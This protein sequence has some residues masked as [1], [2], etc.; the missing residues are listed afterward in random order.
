[1]FRRSPLRSTG[2]NAFAFAAALFL[3][4]VLAPAYSQ[5]MDFERQ[6][7]RAM[8]SAIKED[9]K[10]NYFDPNFRGIDLEARFKK[11]DEDI[12]AAAALGQITTI[13]AQTLLDLHDSHTYFVPPSRYYQTEYGWRMQMIG[14]KCYVV[15]VKP[16]TDAASKGLKEG[17][18]LVSV[19]GYNPTRDSLWIL[20]YFYNTLAP[21]RQMKLVVQG[22]DGA[23][24]PLEVAAK[25]EQ[26]KK[27]LRD[28]DYYS[29]IRA[30]ENEAHM[31]RHIYYEGLDGDV[32]LW[33]MPQFD[34]D[35]EDV[36][37]MMSK[38]K[39]HKA[40]ILDLRG[41]GGG[42]EITMQR[43]LGHLFDRDINIG[44]LKGRKESKPVLAKTRGADNFKGKLVVLIDS[45]S[46]SAAEVVAR[47]VQL[48]KRGTV[49]GDRSAGAVMRAKFYEHAH[50]QDIVLYYGVSVTDSDLVMTD[51]KS[52]EGA[53]VVPDSVM[54]PTAA[55]LAARRDPVLAHAA[56]LVG[57]EINAEKAGTLFPFEW[58]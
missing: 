6:R 52:L 55:D 2:A 41:N 3:L 24:R 39:K 53:G 36:D 4:S 42:Y 49:I 57:L 9:I 28:T 19:N 45:R 32:F 21:Q 47:V 20:N 17:D 25:V 5:T 37:K 44:D 27:L 38:V 35:N 54:L 11:A 22:P 46:G 40:L 58:K 31:N 1:M 26:G 33:K 29:M 51:G 16:G 7:A 30:Y 18:Q 56:S 12:K 23:L 13:I 15:A 8:L 14:D 43:L 50:G 48:E 34:L 10:K